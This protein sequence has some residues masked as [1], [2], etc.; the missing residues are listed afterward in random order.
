MIYQR[1]A[2]PRAHDMTS[3]V[4]ANNSI[5][6]K[7]SEGRRPEHLLHKHRDCTQP[8]IASLNI[9]EVISQKC[10]TNRIES[11][12]ESIDWQSVIAVHSRCQGVVGCLAHVRAYSMKQ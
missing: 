8:T 12:K 10:V 7:G 9:Y 3:P 11:Y 4:K 2:H 6:G 5:N 1:M